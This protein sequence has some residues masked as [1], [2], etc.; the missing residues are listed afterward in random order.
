MIL[1]VLRFHSSKYSGER[2]KI[3]ENQ[4]YLLRTIYNVNIT[5]IKKKKLLYGL[6]LGFKYQSTTAQI[7]QE[8][9]I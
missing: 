6:L 9:E 3:K 5:L 4:F 7:R 1:Q 8:K 2:K